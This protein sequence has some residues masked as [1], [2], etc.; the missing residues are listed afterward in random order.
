MK[1]SLI[2]KIL[3]WGCRLTIAIIFIQTLRHKFLATDESVHIFT[4][5]G[6]E[7]WGRIL[8]GILELLASICILFPRTV[9]M[10]AMVTLVIMGGA[11]FFHITDLGIVVL[12]DRGGL[13]MLALTVFSFAIITL[14]IHRNEI[15]NTSIFKKER[16]TEPTE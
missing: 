7:P 14:Y 16:W 2:L 12:N 11:I 1:K 4:Q 5:A 13:F 8:T 3:S 9:W 6:V 15:G 10:G